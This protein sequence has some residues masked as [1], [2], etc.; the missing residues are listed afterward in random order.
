M[1]FARNFNM[2]DTDL[3][4]IFRRGE[5]AVHSEWAVFDVPERR[6][7]EC[8][9]GADGASLYGV[10]SIFFFTNSGSATVPCFSNPQDTE[11][12]KTFLYRC[13]DRIDLGEPEELGT[14]IHVRGHVFMGDDGV[15]Y[16]TVEVIDDVIMTEF[17]CDP[18]LTPEEL[19]MST[20]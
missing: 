12:S 13:I 8:L 9:S 16:A 3:L 19:K 17:G 6:K 1:I 7:L 15:L 10:T 18:S 2:T 11:D 20:V 4:Y 5:D 14:Q